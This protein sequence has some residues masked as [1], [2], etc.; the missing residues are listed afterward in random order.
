MITVRDTMPEDA[1]GV[2]QV[3][4]SA[5]ATLRQTYRPNQKALRH[6]RTISQDL[7]RLVAELDGVIFGTMQYFTD[8]NAMGIIGLGVH[9]DF[10]RQGVARALIAEVADR[11]ASRGLQSV[12]TRT[13]EQT[14]NVPIFEA[15][16][17]QVTSRRPDEY[18]ESVA[19]GE[20]TDVSLEM[21]INDGS[22]TR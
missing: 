1:E 5:T 8:G 20:L 22:R 21:Q 7:R 16:G 12:V 14:C 11:A 17:F 15:L 10:R 4:A 3:E 2:R 6:K 9:G 18:S 19:G 13:V